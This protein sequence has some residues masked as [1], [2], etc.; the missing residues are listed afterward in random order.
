MDLKRIIKDI[1]IKLENIDFKDPISKK[2]VPDCFL[3]QMQ[4]LFLW[5]I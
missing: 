1:S 4:F 3:M 2:D 5:Q